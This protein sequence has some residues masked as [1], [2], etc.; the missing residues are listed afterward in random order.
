MR[1]ILMTFLGLVVMMMTSGAAGKTYLVETADGG[2]P[3][4]PHGAAAPH[5]SAVDHPLEQ[6]I[7]TISILT[8]Q[9]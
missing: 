2:L 1:M 7:I 4:A 3:S 5:H 8:W 6:G 9:N